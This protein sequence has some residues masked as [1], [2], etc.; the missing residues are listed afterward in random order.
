[1]QV[2]GLLL[3]T[4]SS[5]HAAQPQQLLS[6]GHPLLASLLPAMMPAPAPQ[7]RAHHHVATSAIT[8]AEEPTVVDARLPVCSAARRVVN[9]VPP[10][11]C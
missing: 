8:A 2:I 10:W 11:C 7:I 3:L 1:M 6:K 5:N 9:C 4:S